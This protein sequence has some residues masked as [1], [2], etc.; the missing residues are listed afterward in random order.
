MLFLHLGHEYDSKSDAG[1]EHDDAG[2]KGEEYIW[3]IP[4]CEAD[5]GSGSW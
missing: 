2:E 5:S 4:E 1:T 3:T